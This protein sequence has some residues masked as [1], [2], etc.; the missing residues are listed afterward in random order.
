MK[1]KNQTKQF[2]LKDKG[3]EEWKTSH[4]FKKLSLKNRIIIWKLNIEKPKRNLHS[5]TS[6]NS[7]ILRIR[8]AHK[9]VDH[10]GCCLQENSVLSNMV[11]STYLHT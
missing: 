10:Q 6:I 11:M 7:K 9:K 8:N 5:R 2:I 3:E 1:K 4:T